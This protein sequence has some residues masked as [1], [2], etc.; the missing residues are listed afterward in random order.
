MSFTTIRRV[1]SVGVKKVQFRA[2]SGT[3]EASTEAALSYTA[4]DAVA[5]VRFPIHSSSHMTE[6]T[7]SIFFHSKI[8]LVRF[9]DFYCTYSVTISAS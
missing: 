9:K 4:K 8:V 2:L 6:A 7:S 1:A 3:H 5:R